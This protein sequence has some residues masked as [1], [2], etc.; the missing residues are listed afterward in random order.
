MRI[1]TIMQ[2]LEKAHGDRF[3]EI[4][5]EFY[6]HEGYKT[7]LNSVWTID[8][9]LEFYKELEDDKYVKKYIEGFLDAKST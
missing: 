7:G 8:K 1:N 6:Y 9:F 5:E 3:N 4:S 2:K